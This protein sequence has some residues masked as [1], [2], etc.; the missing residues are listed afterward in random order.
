MSLPTTTGTA[1]VRIQFETSFPATDPQFRYFYM[2]LNYQIHGVWPHTY[3]EAMFQSDMSS[4]FNAHFPRPYHGHDQ[5]LTFWRMNTVTG[6]KQTSFF[7]QT[8]FNTGL[9]GTVYSNYFSLQLNTG[10]PGPRT[11]ARLPWSWYNPE[12]VIESRI[13]SFFFETLQ[14]AFNTW[15]TT[16]FA[17]GGMTF[18]PVVWFRATNQFNPISAVKLAPIVGYLRKRRLRTNHTFPADPWPSMW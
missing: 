12:F 18:V 4:Y 13:N 8:L 6:V 10:R 9:A 14:T 17:I 11:Y 16:D 3:T 1:G 15:F 2:Q 5:A 7:I